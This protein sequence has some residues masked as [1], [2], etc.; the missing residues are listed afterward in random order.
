MNT[1]TPET[2]AFL[3]DR[4]NLIQ[5]G[6]VADFA[7]DLEV[8][9]NECKWLADASTETLKAIRKKYG[10][11]NRDLTKE[12]RSDIKEA[13]EIAF[14]WRKVYSRTLQLPFCSQYPFPWEKDE[15]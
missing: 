12:M 14:L 9:M 4:E 11:A 7:G 8:R 10:M 3:L 1:K 5:K 13:R 2:D 15:L 6:V